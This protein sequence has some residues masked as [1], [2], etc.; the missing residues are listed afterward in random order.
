MEARD[1]A[2]AEAA[3]PFLGDTGYLLVTLGALFSISSALNAT[4]YGG[5]NI[6][7]ALA[8]DG[9]LPEIFERKSWFQAPEGLYLTAGVGLIF[10][11][12]FGLNGIASITSAIF[13]V[14]YLFVLLSHL[15]LRREVGGH[16]A[17]IV[18][19]LC[20]VLLVFFLL[21]RYQ[22]QTDR[23]AFWATWGTLAGSLV[24]ETLYRYL[25]SRILQ[26]RRAGTS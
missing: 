11:I 24:V 12:A 6:A 1:Y 2:L 3:K 22:W 26:P 19:G 23:T 25:T 10:A 20:V 4:L 13:M 8:K 21:M 14:I 17:V 16:R 18:M 5:A 9:E 7:Y 15:R